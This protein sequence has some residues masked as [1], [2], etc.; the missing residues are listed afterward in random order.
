M[1]FRNRREGGRILGGELGR[2]REVHPMV[3]GLTGGGVP[4]A[5]EVARALGADLD[6]L[7]ARKLGAPSHPEY[8]IGAIAEGGAVY[9]RRESLPEVGLDEEGV[10]TIAEREAVELAR[11]VRV[12]R[13]PFAMPDL[14][15]RTVIVV[16]DGVATGATAHAAARSARLRGAGRVILAAPV[17]A[18]DSV[19]ELT[20]DFDDVVAVELPRPLRAVG[21]WYED[22]GQVS[23]EEVLACLS[24]GSHPE[25]ATV[26]IP[27]SDPA[28]RPGAGF[29]EADLA[30]PPGAKGLVLFVHGSGSTRHSPRNL[31]VAGTLQRSGFA[32]LLFDLL[33]PE[34]AVEDEATARFRF[35]V[36]LLTSRV[37]AA[38]RWAAK[39]PRTRHM[40]IGY[41]GASTGAAA[42]LEAAAE[43]PARVAAVV[44]RG[45]RPDLVPAGT[46]VRVH[47]P[48]LLLVGSRDEEVLG[49]NRSVLRHL[50]EAQLVVVGGATH[51]FE[52]AGAL[53]EV[54]RLAAGWFKGR[55]HL[56]LHG[57]AAVEA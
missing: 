54:A 46:L 18:A 16:D 21:N 19:P 14:S 45:G 50:P 42:A 9:V 40:G 41:F 49:H 35:D 38:T 34:E 20:R 1:I 47:V 44:S 48:V 15:G 23:D 24:E 17:I 51:L 53:E 11:R 27:I 10:A 55:L 31:L 28:P 13:G 12:Y 8:G 57:T 43:N 32:T 2:Y 39:E 26:R 7:V 6:V 36:P 52:E 4:V 5:L 33:T 22:F 29:L 37:L 56:S 25:G 30:I 3:L